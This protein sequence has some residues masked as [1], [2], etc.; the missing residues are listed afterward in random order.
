[1]A[2]A[3]SGVELELELVCLERRPCEPERW[4]ELAARY[5]L[6]PAPPPGLGDHLGGVLG[7]GAPGG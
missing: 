2:A 5:G 3:E 7:L 4:L 1:M 6:E